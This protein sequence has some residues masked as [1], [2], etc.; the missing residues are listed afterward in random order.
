MT[1]GTRTAL[2]RRAA[3]TGLLTRWRAWLGAA[4]ARHR[5]RRALA[6]LDDRLLRDVAVTRVQQRREIRRSFWDY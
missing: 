1:F 2:T 5:Q 3:R 4:I 6:D